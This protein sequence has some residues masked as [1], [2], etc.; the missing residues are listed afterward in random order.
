VYPVVERVRAGVQQ[1]YACLQRF[2]RHQGLLRASALSFDTTLGLIPLLAL[3]FV[4]LKLVG[5]QN[6]LGP[7]LVEQLA[8]SSSEL[9]VRLIDYVNRLE[10]GSLGLF[11]TA[12]LLLMLVMLLENVR[13]AFNAVWE[14]QEQRSLLQRLAHYLVLLGAVPLLLATALGITSLLQSRELVQ[15]LISTNLVGDGVLLLFKLIPYLCSCLVLLL[16]YLLIP[17]A[18]VRFSS[19]LVGALLAGAVWQ[20]AHWCYFHFQIGV[21]RYNIIYGALAFLPFLL[22][23]FFTSWLLVLLGLELVR[24]HQQRDHLSDPAPYREEG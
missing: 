7:Y 9:G 1:L 23:W 12:G 11:G 2:D 8:G 5:I 13:D 24:Y 6:L 21:A 4:G 20:A 17:C 15:W 19:A 14:V 3:V 16:A 22:I 10:V 18:P